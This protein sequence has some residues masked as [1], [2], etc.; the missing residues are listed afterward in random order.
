MHFFYKCMHIRKEISSHICVSKVVILYYCIYIRL[1]CG[2]VLFICIN[3]FSKKKYR[4]QVHNAPDSHRFII[5]SDLAVNLKKHSSKSASNHT[6][7]SLSIS[8][9]SPSNSLKGSPGLHWPASQ[10]TM[11]NTFPLVLHLWLRR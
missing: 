9:P 11:S 2:S 5:I 4:L 3:R 7:P 6:H 8:E 10:T 1:A